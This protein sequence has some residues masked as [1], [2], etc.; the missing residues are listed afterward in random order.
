[1]NKFTKAIDSLVVATVTI[2][3]IVAEKTGEA[4]SSAAGTAGKA[5]SDLFESAAAKPG[6]KK[7]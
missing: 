3:G 6:K 4:V 5:V 7:S 2:S 1:M